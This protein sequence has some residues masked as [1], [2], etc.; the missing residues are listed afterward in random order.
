M[1]QDS[2]VKT[3]AKFLIIQ[4]LVL[5][6]NIVAIWLIPKV[7]QEMMV[8]YFSLSILILSVLIANIYFYRIQKKIWQSVKPSSLT[9]VWFSS[10]KTMVV[11][12][13]FLYCLIIVVTL[14]LFILEIFKS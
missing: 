3:S 13:I 2:S 7:T 12:M 8:F 10:I 14:G 9:F 1:F 4:L 5:I 6:G 11:G